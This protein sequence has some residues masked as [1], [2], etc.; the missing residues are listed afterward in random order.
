VCTSLFWGCASSGVT[1][2][3]P[4]LKTYKSCSFNKSLYYDAMENPQNHF[5]ALFVT[6]LALTE[7]GIAPPQIMPMSSCQTKHV[8]M[9][10]DVITHCLLNRDERIV[11]DMYKD[12]ATA[13]EAVTTAAAN[14]AR[15]ILR[16]PG[17]LQGDISALARTAARTDRAV[18]AAKEAAA[19]AATVALNAAKENRMAHKWLQEPGS[20]DAEMLPLSMLLDP[21]SIGRLC[22]PDRDLRCWGCF[23]TDGVAMS[24]Q[25]STPNGRGW[26]TRKRNAKKQPDSSGNVS[27]AAGDEHVETSSNA[28]PASADTVPAPRERDGIEFVSKYH[29]NFLR[30][31]EGNRATVD[32]NCRD[33]IFSV[34]TRGDWVR[35]TSSEYE[36]IV[37][38]KRYQRILERELQKNPEIGEALEALSEH[39]FLTLDVDKFEEA[40]HVWGQYVLP[41]IKYYGHAGPRTLNIGKRQ[42]NNSVARSG[43]AP[44]RTAV[45]GAA[46]SDVSHAPA[47]SRIQ[48]TLRNTPGFE[49]IRPAV[50]GMTPQ[51]LAF[52]LAA[53]CD[54]HGQPLHMK[55]RLNGYINRQKADVYT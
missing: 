3:L 9:I 29:Q 33:A 28:A 52:M 41:L 2:I 35:F 6:A 24:V 19:R 43:S 21:G 36:R 1:V 23:S 30:K 49:F 18:V 53:D 4:I 32:F 12:A 31:Y 40:L 42:P 7:R 50:K 27:E 13:K 55:L 44:G 37:K 38:F 25:Y 39:S 34:N 11:L 14:A 10:K 5:A 54:A 16:Q 48:P 46:G 45:S 26:A 47:P 17:A 20:I 15:A 22:R 51:D 8:S